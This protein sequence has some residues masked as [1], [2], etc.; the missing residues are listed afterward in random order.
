MAGGGRGGPVIIP[1]PNDNDA[2]STNANDNNNAPPP[3]QK[4]DGN[5]PRGEGDRKTTV[6]DNDVTAAAASRDVVETNATSAVGRRGARNLRAAADGMGGFMII[7]SSRLIVGLGRV[8]T[9]ALMEVEGQ[10]G[11][12]Q[13][14]NN[15]DNEG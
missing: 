4:N 13:S 15:D 8:V 14:C 1:H 10:G 5:A 11:S 6:P 2:G 9:E 3:P 7:V 12:G